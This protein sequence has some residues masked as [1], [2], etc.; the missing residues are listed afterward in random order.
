MANAPPTMRPNG[1]GN[2]TSPATPAWEPE[3]PFLA[4]EISYATVLSTTKP[5]VTRSSTIESPFTAEYAG[6][7][8][9]AGAH[10]EAFATLIGEL[11]DEEFTEALEDLVNDAS[12]VLE[13]GFTGEIGDPERDRFV[14]E[15][16]LRDY[17]EPLRQSADE[18]IDRMAAELAGHD[19]TAMSES[20]LDEV[21]DRFTPPE[22]EFS[23]AFEGFL[24]GLLKK[25]KSAVKG[26]VKLASKVAGA[27]AFPHL[28]ILNKLKGLIR[29]LLERVLRFAI[30]KLPVAL[31]PL[32]GQLAQRF[33]GI[34]V[35]KPA[36]GG[37]LGSAI[38]AARSAAPGIAAGI[39]SGAASIAATNGA[40]TNGASSMSADDVMGAAPSAADAEPQ[41]ADADQGVDAAAADPGS[42]E[43]ELDARLAGYM[44]AGEDFDQEAAVEELMAAYASPNLDPMQTLDRARR[45]FAD[46]VVRR[47]DNESAGPLLEQFLPAIL[48]ALKLGIKVVGRPRVVKFL[49]GLLAKLIDKYVGKQQ[50]PALSSALVDTGLRLMSLEAPPDDTNFAGETLAAT[51]EDTV[52]RLVHTAPAAAWES[53]PLLETYLHEAFQQAAAAHFPDRLIRDELHETSRAGGAWALMP[54][55]S[56]RKRYKKYSRVF[57]VSITPQIAAAVRTFGGVPLRSFLKDRLG[58]TVDRPTRARVHVYEAIPGTRL[59]IIA[60]HERGVAGLGSARRQAWSLFHPL[61]PRAAGVLLQEPGL[62][63]RVPATFLVRRRT[64]AVGQRFYYLEVPGARVRIIPRRAGKPSRPAR[65]TQTRVLFDFPKKQLRV[66]LYYSEADAQELAKQLRQKLPLPALLTALKSRHDAQ[67]KH[68][69]SGAPTGAVRLVHETAPTEELAAP[70]IALALRAVG[71]RLADLLVTALLD[72]LK[73]ELETHYDR[74]VAA[75][76]RAAQADEDGVTIVVTFDAAPLLEQ[77]RRVMKPGAAAAASAASLTRAALGGF[78]LDIRAGFA[79]S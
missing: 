35:G 71:P 4:S 10:A 12:A 31:R 69:L 67:L 32:A 42:L 29:P 9:R 78:T 7:E 51:V 21:L 64:A 14:M 19:V 36:S 59:S 72:A 8:P 11:H 16:T 54:Q 22:G 40:A 5:S 63:R 52:S 33:L 65:S 13:E 70:L 41:A 45:D 34:K 74:F 77:L 68:I 61:T 57:D 60:L 37:L 1:T 48:P 66:A 73:K 15:R 79:Q 6:E 39:S 49:A 3:T 44:L 25:A 23:P 53:E 55:S 20:E 2:G 28:L 75:L 24:G 62:A 27:V 76:D 50:A 47:E 38:E 18:I 46:A 26:A 56:P 58:L 43:E 30:D 17:F